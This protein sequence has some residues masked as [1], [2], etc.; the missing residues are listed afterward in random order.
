MIGSYSLLGNSEEISG[1]RINGSLS[2]IVSRSS[3][4]GLTILGGTNSAGLK[5]RWM[6]LSNLGSLTTNTIIV[7][8]DMG[9]TP[10]KNLVQIEDLGGTIHVLEFRNNNTVGFW[11][12]NQAFGSIS[13]VASISSIVG[14][15]L[16]P[17]VSDGLTMYAQLPEG[18]YDF[19][20]T[21]SLII[22]TARS[23][24]PNCVQ[25]LFG[26][27]LYFKNRYSLNRYPQDGSNISGAGYDL[28][29]GL[30]SDKWGEITS[31]V[32]TFRNIFA[33]IKGATYSHIL[34]R[35]NNG[36]WQY[37]ARIPSPG[38]WVRQMFLSN[39]PDNID[40][41]WCIFGNSANPGY[42]LNPMVNPLQAGTYSYVPTG[43]FTH[44]IFD[45]GMAEETGGF[46]NTKINGKGLG[47]SNNITLFY[48]LDGANPVTQL[49]VIATN[50]GNL[51]FGS[52][53]GL[54]G[55]TMQQ[56]FQ[57]A[58]AV[59]GTTPVFRSAILNYL[60]D[61]T[62]RDMFDLTIDYRETARA[63]GLPVEGI[64]ATMDAIRN[65][66]PLIPFYY[67]L[68]ATRHVK[69]LDIPSNEKIEDD[70]IL[71]GNREGTIKLRLVEMT[72]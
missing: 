67:G 61:P 64:I 32:S 27:D 56:K 29:D 69:V 24:E 2:G 45:G 15:Y 54:E 7:S 71:G 4:I 62:K 19:D 66:K 59:S 23:R 25:A 9:V 8:A 1:G 18:I 72:A 65:T 70:K 33:S 48:G 26:Q 60:K 30:P 63:F 55:Y 31:M 6:Q 47:D 35:E 14:S 34:S 44:P 52:P 17:L 40:R 13:I 58:G 10:I 12:A 57:L 39:T 3:L 21:P 49:G 22:N 50:S 41:L 53:T 5:N 46:F 51:T 16:S 68:V 36:A 43:H 37:Y 11:T 42:F 28:E 38:V 20:I